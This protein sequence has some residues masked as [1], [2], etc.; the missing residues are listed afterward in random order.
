VRAGV[1]G[2][3]CV[4]LAFAAPAAAQTPADAEPGGSDVASLFKFLGGVGAGLGAHEAGHLLFDALFDAE[5][6]IRRV[7]L[8]GVPFFAIAHRSDLSPRRE[9][10][11]SSSGFWV[12]HAL[13]EWILTSRPNLRA[14]QAPFV[15]GVLA[16]N[17][18]T[19]VGYAGVALARVGPPERD[20]RG[21]AESSRVDERVI[22][23]M[24]LA[25][26][27]LDGYR[28]FKPGSRWAAWGSRGVK[29]GLVLLVLR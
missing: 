12:Q 17:V 5:P 18:L 8:F 29:I 22:G 20:T 28:Y 19:S 10:V 24:T 15:K 16:F 4:L 7:E 1:L 3:L 27:V 21:M 23:L 11:V 25:P 6:H 2:A 26:A 9:F 13:D 14:E